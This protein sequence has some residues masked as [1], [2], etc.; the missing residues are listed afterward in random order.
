MARSRIPVAHHVHIL[1]APHPDDVSS[2]NRIGVLESLGF[3]PNGKDIGDSR[4]SSL[5]KQMLPRQQFTIMNITTSETSPFYRIFSYSQAVSDDATAHCL[6]NGQSIEEKTTCVEQYR[7]G[8]SQRNTDL[9]HA[10]RIVV[11]LLPRGEKLLGKV[12]VFAEDFTQLQIGQDPLLRF[13]SEAK[14]EISL[15]RLKGWGK[16]ASAH[17]ALQHFDFHI[18][19]AVRSVLVESFQNECTNCTSPRNIREDIAKRLRKYTKTLESFTRLYVFQEPHSEHWSKAGGDDDSPFAI[20]PVHYHRKQEHVENHIFHK[21]HR[22]DS[23]KHLHTNSPYRDPLFLIRRKLH[24]LLTILVHSGNDSSMSLFHSKHLH[25]WRNYQTD[26]D[27]RQ[28]FWLRTHRGYHGE[29]FM[30]YVAPHLLKLF[31]EVDTY[32]ERLVFLIRERG[33]HRVTDSLVKLQSDV[34]TFE[35]QLTKEIKRFDDILQC[36]ALLPLSNDPLKGR[37][38]SGWNEWLWSHLTTNYHITK[39]TVDMGESTSYYATPEWYLH[40]E[41]K[42]YQWFLLL[43]LILASLFIMLI[44]V[45]YFVPSLQSRTIRRI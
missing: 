1:V 9:D 40:R 35:T 28:E 15:R 10:S 3:S 21:Y 20:R 11:I 39:G 22:D 13:F 33:V 2:W 16:T 4:L 14:L 17:M 42:S 45:S 23:L 36:C 12:L 38:G 31:D 25:P 5:M 34:K 26:Q 7:R 43:S 24:K 41:G 27:L 32:S 6:Y 19:G 18:T 44:G 37:E 8:Q 29:R 30:H